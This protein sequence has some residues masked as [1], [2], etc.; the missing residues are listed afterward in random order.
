M[1][2]KIRCIY[3]SVSILRVSMSLVIYSDWKFKCENLG[4]NLI[5]Y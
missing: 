2:Q 1:L 5:I 4:E 3:I